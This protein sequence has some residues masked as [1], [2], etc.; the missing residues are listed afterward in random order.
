MFTAEMDVS[1]N[2][3]PTVEMS[4]LREDDGRFLF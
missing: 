3:V 2:E 4:I 1:V